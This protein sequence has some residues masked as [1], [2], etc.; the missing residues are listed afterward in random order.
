[1]IP[2]FVLGFERTY[3]GDINVVL[4]RDWLKFGDVIWYANAKYTVLSND[5]SI[6]EI[7][8]RNVHG[9]SYKLD[10]THVLPVTGEYFVFQDDLPKLIKI[11]PNNPPEYKKQMVFYDDKLGV[12]KVGAL[13]YVKHDESGKFLVYRPFDPV[14]MQIKNSG[15]IILAT[16]NP[17]HYVDLKLYNLLTKINNESTSD[18]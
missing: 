4:D 6:T 10:Q 9:T 18:N 8:G 12:F 5:G 14:K 13:D 2:I 7:E 11:D 1:M 3:S 15:D 16:F 17:T